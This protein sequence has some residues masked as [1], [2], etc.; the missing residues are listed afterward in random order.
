MGCEE[1]HILEKK[2][3]TELVGVLEHLD[4][5]SCTVHTLYDIYNITYIYM[6]WVLVWNMNFI[7]PIY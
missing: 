6:Y 1:L 3:E 5:F 7:F 4:Y 2:R